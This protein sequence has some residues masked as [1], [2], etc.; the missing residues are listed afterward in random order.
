MLDS[1]SS[2][3]NFAFP[4]ELWASWPAW[5]SVALVLTCLIFFIIFRRPISAVIN[6]SVK[7]KVGRDGIEVDSPVTNEPTKEEDKEAQVPEKTS[8]EEKK[9]EIP[10]AADV[11]KTLD[12]WRTEM[13]I[14]YIEKDKPRLE[15]AYKKILELNSDSGSKKEDDITYLK[16]S[17]ALGNTDAITQLKQKLENTDIAYEVNVALGFCFFVSDDFDRANEYYSKAVEL[18]RDEDEKSGSTTNLSS[19]LYANGEKK[20]AVEVLIEGLFS[21]KDDR[22]KVKLYVELAELYEKQKDFEQRA[23]VLD[24]ALELQ[25][26]DPDLLFKAAYA[27]SQGDYDEMS[28]L[29]YR[30]ASKIDPENA[31]VRNN[32]GVQ[33]EKLGM[34][35]KSTLNYKEAE[36]LGENLASANLAYRLMDAGFT[37][38]A[39]EKLNVAKNKEEVHPNVGA[40]ISALSKKKDHEDDLEKQRTEK[41]LL[42]RK[43]ILGF[44]GSKFTKGTNL[45]GVSGIW[46]SRNGMEFQFVVENNK[47]FAFWKEKIIT[48]DSEYKLEG[49]IFNNSSDVTI[50]EKEYNTAK[51]SYEFAEKGTGALFCSEDGLEIRLLRKDKPLY[52][53]KI[54]ILKRI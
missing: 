3:Q 5:G 13:L 42:L 17:H 46:K 16:Y 30:N 31:S 50:F 32:L 43:F 47:I 39:E 33:Y 15:K 20:K 37:T 22:P 4:P 27:Y 23:F 24:K 34:P 53:R 38:E 45:S 54:Y 41:A 52:N 28:L 19:S 8:E 12:D 51:S 10:E 48:Y 29:H 18:A 2:T 21:I 25:P 44:A 14:A 11:P 26:N 7:T 36:L 1:A 40:A 6:R 9:G 49:P 35:I